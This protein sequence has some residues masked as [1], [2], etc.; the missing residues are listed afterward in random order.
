MVRRTKHRRDRN[1]R[2]EGRTPRDYDFLDGYELEGRRSSRHDRDELDDDEEEADPGQ[3]VFD[4]VEWRTRLAEA[5]LNRRRMRDREL[6]RG[7]LRKM[8][9]PE[10]EPQ[11]EPEPDLD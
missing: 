10:P 1:P 7:A 2:D 6:K 8:P 11:P 4:M 9:E 3:R 5:S